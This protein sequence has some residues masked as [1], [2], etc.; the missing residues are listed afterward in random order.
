MAKKIGLDRIEARLGRPQGFGGRGAEPPKD[1]G[2]Q[3]GSKLFGFGLLAIF[4]VGAGALASSDA[5]QGFRQALMTDI[6]GPPADNYQ[7]TVAAACDPGWKDDRINRDQIHCYMTRDI[8]RLCNP[9]ERLALAN[10]L[11]AYQT[12]YNAM[13]TALAMTAFGVAKNPKVMDMGMAD[14][15]SR[16]AHLSAAEQAEQ[17]DKVWQM[18]AEIMGPAQKILAESQN[19]TTPEELRADVKALAERGFLAA[20]DFPG[21]MP[22]IVHDGLALAGKVIPTA[23]P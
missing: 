8:A 1:E 15:K 19:T 13:D 3:G 18:S 2:P 14:A 17:T 7:S 20:A 6:L 23:C 5:G 21:K 16:D 4:V 12:A 11:R 9:R 22:K 10:K